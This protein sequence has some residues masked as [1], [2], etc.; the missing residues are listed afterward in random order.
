MRQFDNETLAA[1]ATAST[2]VHCECP[3]HLV[4]L[5]RSLVAFEKYSTE[6]KNNSPKDAELHGLLEATT[7]KARS[8]M[9]TALAHVVEAEGVQI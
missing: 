2:A 5:I 3:H 9:E 8:L 4:E 1:I 7:A 6:C